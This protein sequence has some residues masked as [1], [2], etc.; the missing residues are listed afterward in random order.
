MSEVAIA[1]RALDILGEDHISSLSEDVKAARTLNG[2]FD[3]VRDSLLRSYVW[4]FAKTRIA[5]A[6]DATPP[7]GYDNRYALPVDCLRILWVATDALGKYPITDRAN[8]ENYILTNDDG[9]IYLCYL[10]QVTDTTKFDALFYET[11]AH[12]LAV[13]SAKKIGDLSKTQLSDIKEDLKDLLSK[14]VSV[15]ATEDPPEDVEDTSWVT[16]RV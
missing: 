8:E 9:P 15:D 10:K 7:L 6:A 5:L 13:R 11:L 4:N 12:V 16:A 14:A 1:N 3:S 2:M